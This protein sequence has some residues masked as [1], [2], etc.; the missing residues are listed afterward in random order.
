M[1]TG[2]DIFDKMTRRVDEWANIIHRTFV[3]RPCAGLMVDFT[4]CIAIYMR[5]NSCIWSMFGV[6]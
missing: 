3:S 5:C 4:L 1:S 2:F 6:H